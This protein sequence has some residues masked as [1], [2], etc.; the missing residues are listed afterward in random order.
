MQASVFCSSSSTVDQPFT[1]GILYT[2]SI[3]LALLSVSVALLEDATLEDCAPLAKPL[4][5]EDHHHVSPLIPGLPPTS[6]PI[7]GV[8]SLTDTLT[9]IPV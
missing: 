8:C 1:K 7:P 9:R 4:G 5:Q 2:V 3:L 6:P